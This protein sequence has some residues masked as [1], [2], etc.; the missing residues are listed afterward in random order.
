MTIR[1]DPIQGI[2]YHR[3]I[4]HL[5]VVQLSQILDL[6]DAFLVELELILLESQSDILQNIVHDAN[7]KVLV[8]SVQSADEDCQK[9]NVAVSDLD[10]LAEDAFQDL[11][12]LGWESA[13][14]IVAQMAQVEALHLVPPSEACGLISE[15]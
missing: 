4:D 1:D 15:P 5:V 7:N 9:V 2:K 3:R 11:N 13:I 12:N 6:C 14:E 8:I 10:W